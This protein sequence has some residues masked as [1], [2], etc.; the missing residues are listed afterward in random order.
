MLAFDALEQ[1]GKP[2]E[3]YFRTSRSSALCSFIYYYIW[4][5]RCRED[6]IKF[7]WLPYCP[8]ACPPGAACK[9]F[10]IQLPSTLLIRCLQYLVALF[11]LDYVHQTEISFHATSQVSTRPARHV[12]V[13]HS[14]L[15]RLA[16]PNFEVLRG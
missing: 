6:T 9:C 5:V 4:S 7:H 15:M 1:L 8:D 13:S 12:S 2:P 10:L 16:N 11:F 14:S 3:K